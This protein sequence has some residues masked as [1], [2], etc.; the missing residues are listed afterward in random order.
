MLL[1]DIRVNASGY[2]PRYETF[3]GREHLVVPV[4]ALVEGVVHA[5]NATEPEFVAAA[6]FTKQ[7]AG[8]NGRPIFEGH[9][10]REGAPVSGNI[11]EVL[12]KQRVGLVFNAKSKSGKLMMEAWLDTAR[13]ASIAPR[14]LERAKA[15]DPIEI[16]VGAFVETDDSTGTWQ[17]KKYRGA[18][19]DLMPDHLALLPEGTEGACSRQMGCGVRAASQWQDPEALM[20]EDFKTLRDVPQAERD[21][22]ADGDFA[23]PNRS[24]PVAEPADVAAAASALGRAKGDRNAIKR[25]IV[26]IAYRKGDAFVAQLPDDWKKKTDMK[27]ASMFAKLMESARSLFRTSQNANEMSNNDLSQRLREALLEVEP[28]VLYVE[29][30]H[31]VTDPTHVV[32]CSIE[33]YANY[34]VQASPYDPYVPY[35]TAM[36]ERAFTLDS[37]GVVTIGDARVEVQPVTKFE[38][39]EGAEPETLAKKNAE[40]GAPCS[41]KTE[42]PATLSREEENMDE[43]QVAEF[44]AKATPEQLK[45]LGVAKAEAKTE[46]KKEEPKVAEVK[47]EAK[48]EEKK[49]EPKVAAAVAPTFD[50]LLATASP[51]MQDSIKSGLKIAADRKAATV[52]ILKDSGRCPFKDE[53]LN[54]KSQTELDALVQLSGVKIASAV[55]FGGQGAPRTAEGQTEVPAAPDLG[56]SIRAARAAAK[57]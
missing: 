28:G 44:L 31:P 22:L 40:L 29:A 55:D 45:T 23:G 13:C 10:M 52:K 33:D 43:K 46:E 16:S 35:T 50:Q 9:P 51:E 32:Y 14:L 47:V 20:N 21:K 38:P 54:A 27:N 15:G 39:V 2:T 7:P 12:A 30:Y 56:A 25:K 24:F 53:E 42:A 41:C 11:P 4:V 1:R 26:S 36:Y 48:T 8:W 37:N 18:W 49:E 6:Q 5:M 57:K 3:E 19:K 17:G 34:A